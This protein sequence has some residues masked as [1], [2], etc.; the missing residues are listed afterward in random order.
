MT[1]GKSSTFKLVTGSVDQRVME[2]LRSKAVLFDKYARRGD[3]AE[4]SPDAV[5]I[6]EVELARTIVA[7]GRSASPGR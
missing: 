2:I 5:D 6:S 4:G 3:M 1:P 7:E